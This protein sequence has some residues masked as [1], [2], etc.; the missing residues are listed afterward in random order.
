MGLSMEVSIGANGED[1]I[2]RITKMEKRDVE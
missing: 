2:Q 1:M